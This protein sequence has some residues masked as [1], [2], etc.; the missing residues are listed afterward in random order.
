MN[1]SVFAFE[2]L[3]QIMHDDKKYY[4]KI[5]QYD[6]YNNFIIQ[7]VQTQFYLLVI[8]FS[9]ACTQSYHKE[10]SLLQRNYTRKLV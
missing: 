7:E 4:N 6:D 2:S 10:N 8:V 1:Y 3:L 5:K 9:K